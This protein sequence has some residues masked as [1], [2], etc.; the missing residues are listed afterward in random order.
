MPRPAHTP[1]LPCTGCGYDLTGIDASTRCPECDLDAAKARQPMPLAQVSA[2]DLRAA[3]ICLTLIGLAWTYLGTWRIVFV[4]D[5]YTLQ[6]VDRLPTSIRATIGF[7]HNWIPRVVAMLAAI[8]T[9]RLRRAPL[10]HRKIVTCFVWFAIVMFAIAA[11]QEARAFTIWPADMFDTYSRS[12]AYVNLVYGHIPYLSVLAIAIYCRAIALASRRR[13]LS[14]FLAA[15]AVLLV[16]GILRG[17][18]YDIYY[19][20]SFLRQSG[21]VLIPPAIDWICQVIGILNI[22]TML[23]L[24]ISTLALARHIRRVALPAL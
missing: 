10:P 15:G 23:L 21:Y 9:W 1:T 2:R 12:A 20:E 17:I 22:P 13:D 7:T 6:A 14:W 4:V 8:A 18:V 11:L 3:C 5:D 19:L 16:L 24:G